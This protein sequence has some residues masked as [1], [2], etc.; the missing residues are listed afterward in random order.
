VVKVHL[1]IDGVKVA[2]VAT[3]TDSATPWIRYAILEAPATGQAQVVFEMADGTTA[4]PLTSMLN[5]AT[6][7][8]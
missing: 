7:G 5:L 2:E 3:V 8:G 1:E 6:I 4:R